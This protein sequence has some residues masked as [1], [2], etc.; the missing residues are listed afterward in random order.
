MTTQIKRQKLSDSTNPLL[1]LGGVGKRYF[2]QKDD[3]NCYTLDY[4]LQY[5][6]ENHIKEMDVYLAKRETQSDYFFCKHFQ[7]CGERG[8]CGKHCEAYKPR[9]GKNGICKHF[10]YTYEQTEKCFTLRIDEIRFVD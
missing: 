5:M 2:F 8:E 7:G 3:E 9:N 10:G 4:H 6:A 1:G